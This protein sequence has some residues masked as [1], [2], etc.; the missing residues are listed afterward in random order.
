MDRGLWRYTRH[1]NYFGDAAVWW[2]LTLLALHHAAGLIGL[3]GAALMTWLL[4]KGTGAKLLESHDRQAAPGLR[5]LRA[6]DERVPP[7]PAEE[8]RRVNRWTTGGEGWSTTPT[9]GPS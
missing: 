4:A 8:D 3:V 6:A 2:G 9:R 7:A 5:R 1:P